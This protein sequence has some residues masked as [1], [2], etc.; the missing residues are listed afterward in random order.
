M[1]TSKNTVELVI[2]GDPRGAK[3][4]L[5]EVGQQSMRLADTFKE[6][7]KQMIG[8]A[9][10]MALFEG[11]KQAITGLVSSG[12][13]MNAQLE[14]ATIQFKVLG[15]SAQEAQKT[16]AY[17]Y[18]YAAKTPFEFQG[19]MQAASI[20]KGVRLDME[21]WIPI[22]GDMAA[23]GQA[24]GL[25]M[26]QVAMAI[27]RVRSGQVGEFFER[28]GA[29]LGITREDLRKYGIEWDNAG[30]L[31]DRSGEGIQRVI[32]AIYEESRRR[33]G[34]MAKE[35]SNTFSGMMS[36]I[37][38]TFSMIQAEV[39]K[40]FFENMRTNVLPAIRD[41][42]DRFLE[43]YKTGGLLAGLKEIIP[44]QAA[45]IAEEVAEAWKSLKETAQGLWAAVKPFAT[46]MGQIAA[47]TFGGLISVSAELARAL[48]DLTKQFLQIPGAALAV[49]AIAG[50]FLLFKVAI[51][52]VTG[53]GRAILGLSVIQGVANMVKTAIGIM[54]LQ[55]ILGAKAGAS[56][57]AR[58]VAGFKTLGATIL[59][60]VNW[61][62]VL[63]AGMVA[64]IILM[65]KNWEEFSKFFSSIWNL[66]GATINTGVK[67]IVVALN[68]MRYGATT[69]VSGM[70]SFIAQQF[71]NLVKRILPLAGKI[72]PESWLEPLKRVSRA[73]EELSASQMH[74]ISRAGEALDRAKTQFKEASSG[75]SEAWSQVKESGSAA[76]NA[77]K[78]D[79]V[80]MANKVKE[81]F[82]VVKTSS[83]DVEEAGENVKN[84]SDKAKDGFN[85]AENAAKSLSQTVSSTAENIKQ[86]MKEL[87][88]EAIRHFS[89]I[90]VLTTRQQADYLRQLIDSYEWS[91]EERWR[92]EEELYQKN[93]DILDEQ[94]QVVKDAYERRLQI[95]EDE[96]E[97]EIEALEKQLDA[98]DE[99]DILADREKAR[100][101][102]EK[103]LAELAE[104][105]RYHEL[106]TGKE[107]QKAIADIDK[108]IA[109][110]NQRWQEQ[111]REWN[112]EDQK[113]QIR[114]E[115][116]LA[117]ERGEER[118]RALQ[119]EFDD[120]LKLYDEQFKEITARLAIWEPD[121]I[122]KYEE[123]GRKAIE[124]LA[125]GQKEG[126]RELE[127][128]QEEIESMLP[129]MMKESEKKA[130][131]PEAPYAPQTKVLLPT[132]YKEING[133]AAMPARELTAFLGLPEPTWKNGTVYIGGKSFF[134]LDVS[135]GT[136]WLPVRDVAKA[137][138]WGV[139]WDEETGN[140]T[141]QK[142]HTGAKVLTGGIA[143]LA[144]GELVFPAGLSA[145]LERLISVLQRQAPV[146]GG[147]VIFNAPLF[148]A[149]KVELNDEQDMEILGRE[150]GRTAKLII[151]GAY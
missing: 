130:A 48:A 13:N 125:S 36:T 144:P 129:G 111:Q 1:A 29:Y 12:L 54:Q 127:A 68:E 108:Q 122:S 31:A 62:A 134:P 4:A 93:L 100:Q 92:L 81:A 30:A 120:T 71:A 126:L 63:A 46:E 26:D 99:E 112:I 10:G 37:R 64:A 79:V 121:Y 109:E 57:V 106:R 55:W 89:A 9:G 33:F 113:K 21:K 138:G 83:E 142:A 35:Q 91:T 67:G 60:A 2:K 124:A 76:W 119:K 32:E 90:G 20:I 133:R 88:Q 140:V 65:R 115:I 151:G 18:N 14:Q 42:S 27:A 73:A 117:R 39:M 6:I 44:P 75:L 38:D 15:G 25:T 131:V 145:K 66:I 28:V 61:W 43:A 51:P 87:A 110:E 139:D 70:V 74:Y 94:V 45:E 136:A 78:T 86:K 11:A 128:V 97:K 34:G 59:G 135:N 52:L 103:K 149:E 3:R 98:L 107:H 96:T 80:S 102:H 82:S 58:I 147:G 24:A 146:G 105:R 53:L 5:N 41:L 118:K 16:V 50:S 137:F 8:F 47:A 143:E 116:D 84:G 22:I 101:E 49:Q 19:I 69:I 56:F 141:L 23:A 95:V 150:L 85:D 40:P 104:E 123:I 77:V 148:Q 72:L 132:E 114:E 7:G 17:L